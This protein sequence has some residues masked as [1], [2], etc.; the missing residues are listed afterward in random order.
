[1]RACVVGGATK[2]YGGGSGGSIEGAGGTGREGSR[3]SER[4]AEKG[5]G[6]GTPR[7]AVNRHTERGRAQGESNLYNLYTNTHVECTLDL[8]L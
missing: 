8:A 7:A 2:A 5:D 1:M 4:E 3:S 6:V